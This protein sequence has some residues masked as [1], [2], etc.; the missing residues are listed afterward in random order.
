MNLCELEASLTYTTNFRTMKAVSQRNPD[1]K[2]K[3][4][5]R[6]KQSRT[7]SVYSSVLPKELLPAGQQDVGHS[8]GSRPDDWETVDLID[9][10]PA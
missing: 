6:R 4:R 3:E 1:L 7:A 10:L 2:E 5:K 8:R 9:F